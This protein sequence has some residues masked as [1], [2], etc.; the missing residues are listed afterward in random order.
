MVQNHYLE[1]QRLWDYHETQF[2]EKFKNAHPRFDYIAKIIQKRVPTGRKILDIGFGDGYLLKVLF[3]KGYKIN[4]LDLS[5]KNVELTRDIFQKKNINVELKAGNVNQMPYNDDCF[6]VIVASELLEHL[7]DD[8]LRR[9]LQEICRCLKSGGL[10]IGT[11]PANENLKAN[12]CFCPKCGH[13]FHRWGHKQSLSR[14]ILSDQ[15]EG[16]YQKVV[17]KEIVSFLSEETNQ[18]ERVKHFLKKTINTF[19]QN[20]AFVDQYFILAWK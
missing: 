15:F 7:T 8:D 19:K 5:I 16:L 14:R 3:R 11:V 1:D 6:D 4:G 12:E 10:F 17:V 13:I 18:Y 2:R 9:G 20:N